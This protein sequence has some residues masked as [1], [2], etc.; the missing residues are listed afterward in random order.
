MTFLPGKTF[1]SFSSGSTRFGMAI[2][3][4]GCV[5]P[6]FLHAQVGGKFKV[7]EL[8]EQGNLKSMLM[9]EEFRMVPG[10]PAEITGLTVEFYDTNE[11][12][13]MKITSPFCTYDDRKGVATSD[14]EVHI[15][16]QSFT[17]DGTGFDYH[18]R[19]ERLN[20]HKDAKVVLKDLSASSNPSTSETP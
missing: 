10:Q 20:I 5:V 17:V 11:E 14:K 1:K 18:A 8:D 9:G 13:R 2:A 15:E 4:L 6:M 3:V 7:P 12:I 16:G 19:E